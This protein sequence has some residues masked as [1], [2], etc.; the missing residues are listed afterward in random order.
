MA[1]ITK[2]LKIFQPIRIIGICKLGQRFFMMNHQSLFAAA[3]VLAKSIRMLQSL[4]SGI[5]HRIAIATHRISILCT[6]MASQFSIAFSPTSH[7]MLG[8]IISPNRHYL[9]TDYARNRSFALGHF[10]SV[11]ANPFRATT[12]TT[13]AGFL[14]TGWDYLKVVTTPFTDKIYWHIAS[15]FDYYITSEEKSQRGRHL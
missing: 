15:W 1:K 4:F 3:A 10:S 7:L 2:N 5:V 6:C 14:C 8:S 12:I 13:E 9:T 11:K